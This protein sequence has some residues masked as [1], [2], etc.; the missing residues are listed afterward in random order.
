V[1]TVRRMTRITLMVDRAPKPYKIS[2]PYTGTCAQVL[3]VLR[4]IGC[5]WRECRL[6]VGGYRIGG[7]GLYS[8]L[9]TLAVSGKTGSQIF[10]LVGSCHAVGVR[11]C[12]D[13]G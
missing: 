3:R 5:D 1:I 13:T 11:D 2:I 8:K 4:T 12:V 7:V 6:S 9:T 10:P